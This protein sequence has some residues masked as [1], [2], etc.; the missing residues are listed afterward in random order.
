MKQLETLAAAALLGGL[1]LV[2]PSCTSPDARDGR[3]TLARELAPEPGLVEEMVASWPAAR[4]TWTES[5]VAKLEGGDLA[6]TGVSRPEASEQEARRDALRDA[7]EQIASY[8]STGARL[9]LE[10]QQ[11]ERSGAAGAD[12]GSASAARSPGG[13]ML[14]EVLASLASPT[15]LDTAAADF[16][17]EKWLER[18]AGKERV[19]WKAWARVPFAEQRNKDLRDSQLRAA[20]QR[21]IDRLEASLAVVDPEQ[22]SAARVRELEQRLRAARESLQQRQPLAAAAELDAIGSGLAQ[23]RLRPKPLPTNGRTAAVPALSGGPRREERVQRAPGKTKPPASAPA[24][25]RENAARVKP[26]PAAAQRTG[27]VAGV[28]ADVRSALEQAADDLAHDAPLAA[29]VRL[30]QARQRLAAVA[31]ELDS[32]ALRWQQ[33]RIDG[34]L[35]ANVPGASGVTAASTLAA[36]RDLQAE[37]RTR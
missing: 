37:L 22:V 18:Q 28:L 36:L 23:A 29:R 11:R 27:R 16:Y 1:L 31:D 34:F 35:E 14:D 12:A 10:Q 13:G 19:V 30:V 7:R 3:P 24:S 6:F 2:A 5:G 32:V 15:L 20:V 25:Q 9:E 17:V 33:R 8:L 21:Q 26:D 4:P